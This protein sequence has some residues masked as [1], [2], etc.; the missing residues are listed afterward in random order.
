LSYEDNVLFW[1]RNKSVSL[2]WLVF[3][4]VLGFF[5]SFFI[6]TISSS[7]VGEKKRG[8][9]N[10]FVY[11]DKKREIALSYIASWKGNIVEKCQ[12]I[13]RIIIHC[14]TTV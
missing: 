8:S 14:V 12:Q 4:K 9:G 10:S 11:L 2:K 13:R 3:L 7:Q 5:R 6:S 1:G